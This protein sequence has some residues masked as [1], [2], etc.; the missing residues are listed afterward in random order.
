MD[1]ISY[2][3]IPSNVLL[4]GAK[5]VQ[6]SEKSKIVS[7]QFHQTKGL[8]PRR[9]QQ[10]LRSG[11]IGLSEPLIAKVLATS[12]LHQRLNVKFS[13]KAPVRP[14]SSSTVMGRIQ[15]DLVDF[16]AH[17]MSYKDNILTVMDVFSRYMWL[18][19]ITRKTSKN[20]ALELAKIFDTF[21]KPGICQHDQGSEFKGKVS[22]LLQQLH[23]KQIKSSPYHPQSQEKIERSHRTLKTR[24]KYD[25]LIS[26]NGTN[27]VEEL[28]SYQT[29]LNNMRKKQLNWKTPHHIFFGRSADCK[30]HAIAKDVRRD[31][32]EASQR[33]NQRAIDR[34]I[35]KL[36][37]PTYLVGDEVYVKLKIGN[38]KISKMKVATVKIVDTNL[39]KF[40]Y[41]VSYS[42]EDKPFVKWFSVKDI[43][44]ATIALQKDREI[45]NRGSNSEVLLPNEDLTAEQMHLYQQIDENLQ[46]HDN[47]QSPTLFNP[48][49]DGSCQFA[50]V[51]YALRDLGVFRSA[52]TLRAEVVDYLQFNNYLGNQTD[53]AWSAIR[54]GENLTDYLERMRLNS[55]FGDQLA[56][57][58]VAEIFNVQVLINSTIGGG[59]TL[60]SPSG[61]HAY[62]SEIRTIVIGHF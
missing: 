57:Q 20:V 28:H 31:A 33:E 19:P 12:K 34:S 16:S 21:G 1:K 36:K 47:F 53:V 26:K 7:E 3:I 9:L 24:M 38:S 52:S 51:S 35:K 37:T 54:A 14:I 55:T 15:I 41:K 8:G 22:D 27:W 29:L 60:I 58:A 59:A 13:N 18:R 40:N 61:L 17:S 56:L 32:M 46:T 10:H 45:Y 62:D 39:D 43:T 25:L 2:Q 42:M 50:A 6:K 23:I 4:D 48:A 30:D 49:P 11:Y 44:G 5:V